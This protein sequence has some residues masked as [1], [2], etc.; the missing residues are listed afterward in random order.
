M[1][2]RVLLAI[3]QEQ[4]HGTGRGLRM[5]ERHP[6]VSRR[7]AHKGG[8]VGAVRM[9]AHV[10]EHGARAIRETEEV[11]VFVA[12]P[13]AHVIEVIHCDGSSVLGEI[14]VLFEFLSKLLHV[15]HRIHLAEVILRRLPD[16]P[17]RQRIR[18]TGASLIDQDNIM[19]AAVVAAF[20]GIE[21]C[22]AGGSRSRSAGQVEY[23]V[24]FVLRI[25]RRQH[26]DI[27]RDL[28][29]ATR[30]PVLEDAELPAE[31]FLVDSWQSA[32]P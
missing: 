13:A 31:E 10:N 7:D 32:G 25:E 14:G 1:T 19:P 16:R 3:S 26:Y 11:N 28:T 20:P 8:G 22:G 18:L 21:R 9:L 5:V 29:A 17:R 27:E 24:K 2:G 30:L 4:I 6:E 23:R 15:V 12:E